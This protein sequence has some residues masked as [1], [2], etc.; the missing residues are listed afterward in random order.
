MRYMMV[1]FNV[2]MLKL[3]KCNYNVWP[4]KRT[5]RH[6]YFTSK[7]EAEKAPGMRSQDLRNTIKYKEFKVRVL[8]R[9][10]YKCMECGETKLNNLQVH[11]IIAI[12]DDPAL[13]FQP[14]NAVT[15]CNDCHKKEHEQ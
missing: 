13:T 4:N 12:K 15:L 9:D 6:F 7:V 8:A 5:K 2:W 1:S 3:L 11:H 14:N 10:K